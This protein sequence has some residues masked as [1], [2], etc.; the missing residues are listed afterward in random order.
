MKLTVKVT[1][2]DI[3]EGIR[4]SSQGCAVNI[5][6]RRALEGAGLAPRLVS[7]G[8]STSSISLVP[9]SLITV[10]HPYQVTGFINR[11]DTDGPVTPFD[12]ELEIPIPESLTPVPAEMKAP[13]RE[14]VSV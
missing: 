9:G 6:M 1:A 14:E 8:I 2:R 4:E 12:F 13:V 3:A 10:N 5:A 7:T 11:F